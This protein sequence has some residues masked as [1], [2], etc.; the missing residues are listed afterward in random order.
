M[1]NLRGTK[2]LFAEDNTLNQKVTL[3]LLNDTHA[4]IEVV[5]NGFEAIKALRED[6]SYDVVLM[7]IQMPVMD[8]YDAVKNI[9]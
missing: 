1:P 5:S 9:R 6:N 2:I 4:N 8:G 7:D 3:G